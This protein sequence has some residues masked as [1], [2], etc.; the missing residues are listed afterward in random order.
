[1]KSIVGSL[2]KY[3]DGKKW[4]Y[5]FD[6]DP[7]PDGKRLQFA[8]G[9]F[10]TRPEANDAMKAAIDEYKKGRTLPVPT[11]ETV[12][13]WVRAWLRD[14]APERCSP[15]THERYCELAG[16]ILDAAEGEGAQLAATPLAEVGKK[17]ALIEAALYRLF[18]IKSQKRA[19]LSAKTVR[20]VANVLRVALDEAFRLE[21]IEVNPMLRVRLPKGSKKDVRALTAE[22]ITSLRAVCRGDWAYPLVETYLATGAR[23]GE[24]LALEWGDVDFLTGTLTISKSLE[25]TEKGLRVKSPKGGKTRKFRIGVSTLAVL[26]F[27]S[28]E[29]QERRRLLG[30]DYQ[31][32]LVFADVDGSHLTPLMVSQNIKR[33]IVKAGIKDASLHSLRHTHASHLLSDAVPI[34]AVSERLGHADVNITLRIYAHMLPTDDT[35]AADSWESVASGPVQ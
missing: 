15:K 19:H 14:Y 10:K 3:N 20:E 9:G 34:T 17:H 23:R 2:S 24:L 13:D 21:K 16:Y 35:R 1:M 4:R 28:E 31:G 8:K 29:Q 25:E 18:R 6:G 32:A 26:R 5:R 30:N 33:R 27:A 11:T 7:Q 12:G 22:E